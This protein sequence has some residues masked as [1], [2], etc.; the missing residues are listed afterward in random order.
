MFSLVSNRLEHCL[1]AK[2]GHFEQLFKTEVNRIS[3]GNSALSSVCDKAFVFKKCLYI[4][5]YMYVNL[6]AAWINKYFIL[7]HLTHAENIPS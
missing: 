7:H 2:V 3:R 1:S 5:L 4:F 6:T